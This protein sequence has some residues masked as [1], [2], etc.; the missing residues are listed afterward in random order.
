MLSFP[1][2]VVPF[3]A[4]QDSNM[5]DRCAFKLMRAT[6]STRHTHTYT[7]SMESGGKEEEEEDEICCLL[8]LFAVDISRSSSARKKGKENL[9]SKLKSKLKPTSGSNRTLQTVD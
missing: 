2:D 6:S 7:N 5:R 8:N 3:P 9:P 4:G 1:F